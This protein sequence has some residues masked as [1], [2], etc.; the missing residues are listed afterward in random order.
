MR[1][2]NGIRVELTLPS[3]I[4]EGTEPS[5]KMIEDDAAPGPRSED[6][7]GEREAA[8]A[9][10]VSRKEPPLA[11]YESETKVGTPRIAVENVRQD[12]DTPV[13]LDSAVEE[14]GDTDTDTDTDKQEKEKVD[15]TG[16]STSGTTTDTVG[17]G[18]GGGGVASVREEEQEEEGGGEEKDKVPQTPEL[19]RYADHLLKYQKMAKMGLPEGAV[20]LKMSQEGISDAE[21]ESFFAG[22]SD[23]KQR[24]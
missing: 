13:P 23:D 22:G 10:V 3:R 20:R 21:I 7:D 14:K 11:R 15:D 5:T 18:G 19:P 8:A 12:G 1:R 4:R 16:T 2:G 6:E 17:G 9:V 24:V